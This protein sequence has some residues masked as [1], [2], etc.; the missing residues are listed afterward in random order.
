MISLHKLMENRHDVLPVALARGIA[1][2]IT[3]CPEWRSHPES[4][5]LHQITGIQLSLMGA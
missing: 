4:P 2:Q 3:G 5:K 1:G